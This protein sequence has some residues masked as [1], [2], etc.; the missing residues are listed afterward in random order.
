MKK[1][2][3]ALMLLLTLGFNT[4]VSCDGFFNSTD[5]QGNDNEQNRSCHYWN[6]NHF[7]F[8]ESKLS[9]SVSICRF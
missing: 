5:E 9:T 6:P 1:R 7:R 4:L 8:F 3:I 2:L